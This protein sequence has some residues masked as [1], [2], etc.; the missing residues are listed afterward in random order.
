MQ[1]V[2]ELD[3]LLVLFPAEKNLLAAEDGGE[4]DQSAVEVFDLDLPLL[5][6]PQ[7]SFDVGQGSD[8]LID[9]LAARVV[10][11]CE[12]AVQSLVV[13]AEPFAQPGKSFQPLPDLRQ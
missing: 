9:R 2:P 10:A 13:P 1:I 8:P 12:Q 4:I 5:K 6:F 3:V 7:G 11:A